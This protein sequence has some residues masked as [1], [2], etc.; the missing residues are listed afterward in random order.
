M[1]L[2]ALAMVE[3]VTWDKGECPLCAEGKDLTKPG[4]KTVLAS[5]GGAG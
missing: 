2:I 5:G 4:S 1:E 3:V